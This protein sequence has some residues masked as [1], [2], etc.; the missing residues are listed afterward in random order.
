MLQWFVSSGAT[1]SI[2]ARQKQLVQ[3]SFTQVEP[4][5][6]RAAEI[7]YAKLFE[8]DPSL[9][10]LFKKPMVEQ[11]K[12]LMA[13]LKVAVKSL[14]DID[15]LVGVLQKLAERHK[16][17]GV[18]VHDYTPVG[19]ALL[20]TLKTGLGELYTPELRDAWV[21]VYKTIADVMRSHVYPD[22]DAEDYQNPINYHR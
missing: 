20:Y 13:T 9:K 14:D 4:I 10:K 22:F 21:A 5:A 2:T 19:N 15:G 3:Q 8:Y 1:M 16:G 18:S 6:D 17:Y 7:F 11:G 12:V